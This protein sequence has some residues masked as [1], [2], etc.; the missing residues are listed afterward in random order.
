MKQSFLFYLVV[1]LLFLLWLYTTLRQLLDWQGFLSRLQNQPFPPSLTSFLAVGVTAAEVLAATALLF[2]HLKRAGLVLSLALLTTF[3][4]YILAIL[5]HLFPR[6]PCSC[7]GLVSALSWKSQL[8]VN[9]ALVLVT[10]LGLKVKK[11]EKLDQN[12]IPKY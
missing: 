5:M 7:T 1:W 3:T 9:L 4:L 11:M 2:P 8:F 12:L 6:V 10:L